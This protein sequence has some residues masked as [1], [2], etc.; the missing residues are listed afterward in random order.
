VTKSDIFIDTFPRSHNIL[1]T[2]VS[3]DISISWLSYEVHCDLN[4]CNLIE[5]WAK[6]RMSKKGCCNTFGSHCISSGNVAEVSGRDLNDEALAQD[7]NWSVQ[8]LS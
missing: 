1:S 6:T 3:L 5:L 7:S 2:V 4:G 8:Q